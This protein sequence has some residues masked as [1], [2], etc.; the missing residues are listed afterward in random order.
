MVAPLSPDTVRFPLFG[1]LDAADS[2][3]LAPLLRR[4]R[5]DAG[6]LIFQRNDPADEVLL[7][8]AGQLRI[9]V[10]SVEGRELAFRIAVPGDTIG[11]I[12]VLDNRRRSADVTALCISEAFALGRADLNRLLISRPQMAMGVIQFLCGRL[13]DTSE[14]LETLALQ[15]IEARLARLLLRLLSAGGP[16]CAE[17]Q[18]TLQITQS[19]IGG[20]IGASRPKVNVAFSVL[21]E[22]GAIRRRG[23][24]LLCRLPILGKIAETAEA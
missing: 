17:M 4:R 18:L 16:V 10:C 13:R 8:T 12:G 1:L 15:R 2:A 5:F 11:E 22:H 7:V 14:Q 23:K 19:E 24:T 9:S 6:R 21:E 20:L 3:A